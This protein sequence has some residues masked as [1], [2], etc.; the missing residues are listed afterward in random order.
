M[1]LTLNNPLTEEEW[2]L[3]E[4][5][6]FD[7]TNSIEFHT[8]HGKTVKFVKCTDERTGDLISRQA[9]IAEFRSCEL[10]P[11][12]GVDANYAI[13]FLEQLPSAQPEL[14]QNTPPEHGGSDKLGVKMGETCTDTISRQAAIDEIRK[15]RFVVDAIE[16]IRALP[17]AQPGFVRCIECKW[18]EGD[19]M[20]NP[21]GVC[22]HPSWVDGNSGHEVAERG[23]CYRAERREEE[24]L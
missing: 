12:G 10:T 3:I 11:D 17:S 24:C 1:T 5:V 16:K 13:D 2:D 19:I 8:K 18:Y 9:V 4:D 20:A 14:E 7:K 22:C 23:W 15:C 21:W 6:D